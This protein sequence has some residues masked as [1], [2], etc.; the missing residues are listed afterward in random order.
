MLHE[1]ASNLTGQLHAPAA[2]YVLSG[3]EP[4]QEP[5]ERKSRAP[6]IS[7]EECRRSGG[8]FFDSIDPRETCSP[9]AST[10]PTLDNQRW[11]RQDGSFAKSHGKQWCRRS[12]PA[13]AG[14]L[15]CLLLLGEFPCVI[16]FRPTQL[17][18]QP[19]C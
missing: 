7:Y 6:K 4:E 3:Q 11:S 16:Q 18:W 8:Y 12:L 17:C 5:R 14:S 13:I 9:P 1:R 19:D 15:R 10:A 2:K